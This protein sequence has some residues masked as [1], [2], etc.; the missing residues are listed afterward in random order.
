M[1]IIYIINSE[2]DIQPISL[3]EELTDIEINNIYQ[4]T[5]WFHTYDDALA[6]LNE[7]LSYLY[8]QNGDNDGD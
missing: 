8:P 1:P 7:L 2:D 5:L 6:E 3:D 4:N